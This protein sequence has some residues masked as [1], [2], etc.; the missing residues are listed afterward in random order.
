MP[1][2]LAP[3]RS[4]PV[5]VPPPH[6]LTRSPPKYATYIH[7]GRRLALGG[8]IKR[9]IGACWHSQ[10]AW[11]MQGV[12]HA[13]SLFLILEVSTKKHVQAAVGCCAPIF[14]AGV[15][16]GNDELPT[17]L[18]AGTR[19]Q[20]TSGQALRAPGSGRYTCTQGGPSW[21]GSEAPQLGRWPS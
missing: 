4:S 21:S 12:L 5:P 7:P 3:I 9:G 16:A 20:E 8:K 18:A 2:A 11:L 19:S 13:A 15:D 17:W 6:F 14:R 1:M 10:A